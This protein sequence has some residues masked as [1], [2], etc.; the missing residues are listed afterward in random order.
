VN[1]EHVRVRV[2]VRGVEEERVM[3]REETKKSM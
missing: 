2:R 1:D 3:M